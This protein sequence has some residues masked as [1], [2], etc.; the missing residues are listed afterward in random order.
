M[1]TTAFIN[2]YRRWFVEYALQDVG[3]PGIVDYTWIWRRS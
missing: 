3:L 2:L 1:E